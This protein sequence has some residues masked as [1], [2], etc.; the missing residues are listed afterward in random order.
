ML[1]RVVLQAL[2]YTKRKTLVIPFSDNTLL[3]VVPYDNTL[4]KLWFSDQNNNKIEI[5]KNVAVYVT[6]T[7]EDLL[8]P[9]MGFYFVMWS[10]DYLINK[11]GV[12]FLK[13]A[14]SKTHTAIQK[15]RFV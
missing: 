9:F 13:I 14:R 6:T 3:H 10:F 12:P 7:K 5:P 11:N 4:A 1:K 8:K 15:Q 2:D